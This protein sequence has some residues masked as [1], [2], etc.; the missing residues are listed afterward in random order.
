MS[1]WKK[2]RFA[3]NVTGNQANIILRALEN[4]SSNDEVEP[5]EY[6]YYRCYKDIYKQLEKQGW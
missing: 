2:Q 5:G 1:D 4:E 3:L 6:S